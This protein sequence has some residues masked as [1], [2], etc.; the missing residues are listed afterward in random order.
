MV[1]DNSN[2]NFTIDDCLAAFEQNW[3]GR[4]FENLVIMFVE[5]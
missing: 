1:D 4:K 5:I 3:D 2:V